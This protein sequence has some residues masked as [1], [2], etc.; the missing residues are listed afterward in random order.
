[1][2]MAD[3]PWDKGVILFGGQGTNSTWLFSNGTWS[4]VSSTAGS[5]PSSR[6][7]SGFAADSTIGAP[8]LF[9][10]L[11]QSPCPTC[12]PTLN[13]TWEFYHG[14]WR[15]VTAPPAPW[16][17]PT[18]QVAD[19]PA[20]GG[21]LLWG[22]SGG[23]NAADTW[24]FA[25]R[26][27]LTADPQAAPPV[28]DASVPVQL[29]AGVSGGLP[30]YLLNWTV[31]NR[32]LGSSTP[33]PEQL[34]APGNYTIHLAASDAANDS[35]NGSVAVELVANLT[36]SA[37]ASAAQAVAG[38]GIRFNSTSAGGVGPFLS[39]WRFGDGG[40]STSRN[41]THV[42]QSAGSYVAWFWTNDSAG[43]SAGVSFAITVT[44][45]LSNSVQESTNGTDVGIPVHFNATPIGGVPPIIESWNFGD[46]TT[47]TGAIVSHSY[48]TPGF[49]T[50]TVWANDSAGGS[51]AVVTHVEVHPPPSVSV[52]VTGPLDLGQFLALQA[53]VLNGTGPFA[54]VWHGLPVGCIP[55]FG[56][57]FQCLPTA[58]GTT[59]VAAMVTDG[60]GV[61]VQSLSVNVTVYPVVAGTVRLAPAQI[62]EGQTSTVSVT[63]SGG[64]PPVSASYTGLPAECPATHLL[65]FAC[66]PS[67]A[68]GT[69]GVRAVLL[70]GAGETATTPA[71]AWTVNA[72]LSV[73]LWSS[74]S[75]L[76]VGDNLSIRAIVS[77]GSAPFTYTFAGLPG[78]CMATAS[79]A[80]DCAPTGAGPFDLQVAVGDAAHANAS[81]NLTVTVDPL[82]PPPAPT[83]GL[84]GVGEYGG[85]GAVV[86][87]AAVAVAW[88]LRRRRTP[89]AEPTDPDEPA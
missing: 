82:P 15:N 86:L 49:Y 40:W 59:A 89:P 34:G 45:V 88:V 61:A 16:A 14:Q 85:I 28:V 54:Y 53:L 63:A 48:S 19:D 8:V 38:V 79:P 1:A 47:T 51:V 81:G 29:F 9:G 24:M 30:P 35:A 70:D 11:L 46:G 37:Q 10:G 21:I 83:V 77:G 42:Y 72:S 44:P 66:T 67:T 75:E 3:S 87:L 4:N 7:E 43:A 52:V 65:R 12:L 57:D 18:P 33:L 5:A 62:D 31:G 41:V 36:V 68:Q 39:I 2:T 13:D 6:Y 32:S 55:G 64:A 23:T 74:V 50:V 76:S 73:V 22:M 69:F 17:R 60:V 80:I 58:V 25:P 56:A 84:S 26:P 27:N 78:G 20:D 71:V